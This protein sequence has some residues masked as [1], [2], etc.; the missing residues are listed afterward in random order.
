[1]QYFKI[2][3]LIYADGKR[4][5]ENNKMVQFCSTYMKLGVKSPRKG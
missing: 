2:I 4:D 3:I 1:M 5:K